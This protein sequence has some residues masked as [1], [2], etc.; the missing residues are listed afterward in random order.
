[1]IAVGFFACAVYTLTKLHMRLCIIGVTCLA[2]LLYCVMFRG[3]PA[4][5]LLY[6]SERF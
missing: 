6:A 1:V 2:P 5:P 3:L 4:A